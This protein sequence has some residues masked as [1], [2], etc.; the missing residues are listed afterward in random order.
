MW[1]LKI[2][3]NLIFLDHFLITLDI[4]GDRFPWKVFT[5]SVAVFA[6]QFLSCA[7]EGLM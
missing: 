4:T 3:V 5:L 2:N 7:V 6:D 1:C